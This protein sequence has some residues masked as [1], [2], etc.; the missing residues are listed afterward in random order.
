MA[1]VGN[2]ISGIKY[3]WSGGKSKKKESSVK[4]K[5][6][7]VTLESDRSVRK[8]IAASSLAHLKEKAKLKFNLSQVYVFL[9]DGTAL[10]ADEEFF[11][12]LSSQSHL[13]L[14]EESYV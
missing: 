3:R 7:K 1:L 11:S 9:P 5:G 12:S 6:Y 10:D 14:S 2:C 4:L 8:G 13:I